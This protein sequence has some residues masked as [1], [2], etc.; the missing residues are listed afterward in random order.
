[1]SK[2]TG[3]WIRHR[4]S[5]LTDW[6]ECSE[7]GY[8]TIQLNRPNFCSN[9]GADMRE[10][11]R[12]MNI[13]STREEFE[14]LGYF[15]PIDEFNG[16]VII[17]TNELHD[18]GFGCMKFALTNHDEVVGCVGGGSDVMHLNGIGG[19]GKPGEDF[20]ALTTNMIRRV[21][22]SID[23]LPNGLIRLFCSYK[24]DIDEFIVSDF[25]LYAKTKG[26]KG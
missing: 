4:N 14:N 21:D 11:D 5:I 25:N 6:I 23:C 17:P 7:C 12:K 26:E 8:E 15:E 10:G 1:M 18:S 13:N 16:V 3:K 9:C 20:E 22:W 19:Y 24:L 2:K